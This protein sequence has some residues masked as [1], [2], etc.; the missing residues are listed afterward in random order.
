M[1]YNRETEFLVT[2]A[3]DTDVEKIPVYE[4]SEQRA[5]EEA[6]EKSSL[7]DG[8]I[9]TANAAPMDDPSQVSN[10]SE[11]IPQVQEE[12]HRSLGDSVAQQIKEDS[13]QTVLEEF[14]EASGDCIQTAEEV[15]L[16][17]GTN[18]MAE[19]SYEIAEILIRV[20]E[21]STI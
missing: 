18:I 9:I 12:I 6:I 15:I 21:S 14:A 16:E 19:H 4:A 11:L 2:V 10:Y 8:Q 3:S 1:S 7:S 17:Y 20:A 13:I 5:V